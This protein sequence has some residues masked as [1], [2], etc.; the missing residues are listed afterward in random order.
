[1]YATDAHAPAVD[2]VYA[3]AR[4][5]PVTASSTNKP[6]ATEPS[7]CH[8]LA[9]PG[10]WPPRTVFSISSRPSRSE[11]Q[12]PTRRRIDGGRGREAGDT[13]PGSALIRAALAWWSRRGTADN[14][15][16]R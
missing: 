9:P 13:G 15:S 11:S 8:R 4:K 3:V 14:G 5:T 16:G 1:M 10:T 12:A 6:A 7:V 2:G